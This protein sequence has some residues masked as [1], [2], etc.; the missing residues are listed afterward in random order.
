MKTFRIDNRDFGVGDTILPQN[1]YQSKLDKKRAD[2]EQVLENNRPTNKPE[3]NSILMLFK[4][5][6]HANHQ[7]TIQKGAKFYKTE[8][9]ENEILHIGDY[10]KV[11]EL[12]KNIEN[13]NLAQQIAKDYWNGVMTNNPKE[14]IFVNSAIV[15]EIKSNSE[16]ERKNT[17]AIRAGFGNFK[18]RT[19]TDG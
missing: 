9:D 11:E 2:V 3:R 13:S 1:N 18:I 10:N 12:F 15:S 5:F 7:W 14:E 4:E 8:I 19:V 17:F 16:K 6:N